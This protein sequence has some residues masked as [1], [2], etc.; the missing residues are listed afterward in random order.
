[1]H[2]EH[3]ERKVNMQPKLSDKMVDGLKD[4]SIEQ[5]EALIKELDATRRTLEKKQATSHFIVCNDLKVLKDLYI[6][7]HDIILPA[8][9][10]DVNILTDVYEFGKYINAALAEK[11]ISITPVE[12]KRSMRALSMTTFKGIEQAN[13][14][15]DFA[16]LLNNVSKEIAD[17]DY[18]YKLNAQM[19][20]KAISE[21]ELKEMDAQ[22]A[23]EAEHALKAET[24]TDT[25]EH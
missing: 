6:K 21:K 24:N 15:N 11:R 8:I 14:L 10:F 2:K 22:K 1:M 7:V 25:K 20:D 4:A 3:M 18:S 5:L 13:I 19:L 16:L 12:F 23:S 9:E 17:L